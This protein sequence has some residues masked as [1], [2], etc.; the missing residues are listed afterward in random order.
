MK[1]YKRHR[2]G[3][4]AIFIMI[5]I[6]PYSVDRLHSCG[7]L[8]KIPHSFPADTWFGFFGSYLP[9]MVLGTITI[10]QTLIIENNNREIKELIYKQ[11][12]SVLGAIELNH[13]LLNDVSYNEY[14]KRVKTGFDGGVDDILKEDNCFLLSFKLKNTSVYE[15]HKM[16]FESLDWIID[17]K[18]LPAVN[19]KTLV[20]CQPIGD[21]YL[22]SISVL[23]LYNKD[24]DGQEACKRITQFSNNA[25]R[26]DLEFLKST[27]ELTFL[28]SDDI[29]RNQ[30]LKICFDIK[31]TNKVTVM[32]GMS[33]YAFLV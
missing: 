27:I 5:I 24:K 19:P 11:R 13:I 10:I 29:T 18:K 26:E 8:S 6:L 3:I 25:G 23:F 12:F 9:G 20:S 28:I 31:P 15:L 16:Q 4:V 14:V 2:W 32:S 1:E 22:Q 21:K 30:E 33:A 17:D 7:Y